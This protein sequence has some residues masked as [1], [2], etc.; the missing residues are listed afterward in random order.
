MI[1]VIIPAYNCSQT[2]N[3]TLASLVAQLDQD[4]KVIVVDDCSTEDITPIIND[5]DDKLQLKYIYKT[6]NQ[7]CGMARQTGI[8]NATSSHLI[9]LDS[10]DVLMPYATETFNTLIS[11]NPQAELGITHF[12]EQVISKEGYPVYITHKN[13]YGWCHGKLYSTNA[14][15]RFGIRNDPAFKWADDRYFNSICC[16]LFKTVSVPLPTYIWTNTTTSVMRKEDA[17]RDKEK[18]KDALLALIASCDFVSK[19]KS[20]IVHLPATIKSY[21]KC[22]QPN[23]KEW[24][25]LQRLRSYQTNNT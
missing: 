19:Y 20:E 2:L 22:I 4:F 10:D 18:H 3:R 16:E 13:S 6:E 11:I 1:D 24:E 17:V 21:E 9:F 23:S 14:I 15:K 8:D 25:L 12:Y 7:G 5:Y